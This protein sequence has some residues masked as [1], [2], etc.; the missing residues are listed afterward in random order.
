MGLLLLVPV[1]GIA[2]IVWGIIARLEPA[3]ASPLPPAKIE[4][5]RPLPPPAGERRG[6]VGVGRIVLGS[7]MLVITGVLLWLA[8]LIPHFS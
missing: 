2:L 5:G 1:A 8:S 6:L 3:P 7:L 4:D